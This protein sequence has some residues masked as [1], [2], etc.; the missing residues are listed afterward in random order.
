MIRDYEVNKLIPY[1]ELFQNLN[2][3][4]LKENQLGKPIHTFYSLR[5]LLFEV[6]KQFEQLYTHPK[7]PSLKHQLDKHEHTVCNQYKYYKL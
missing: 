6:Q 1:Y 3:L 7:V 4:E 2:K 5:N